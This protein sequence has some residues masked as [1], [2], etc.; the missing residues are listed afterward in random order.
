MTH[1]PNDEFEAER[2]AKEAKDK[3]KDVSYLGEGSVE[4]SRMLAFTCF[5]LSIL[6]STPS[7]SNLGT[8]VKLFL[9]NCRSDAVV[10]EER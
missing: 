5:S 7:E 4:F 2:L 1:A 3:K 9:V 8:R 6:L 10:S